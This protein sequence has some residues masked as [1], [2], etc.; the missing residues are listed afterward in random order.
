MN[1]PLI[2]RATSAVQQAVKLGAQ[3]ARASVNRTRRSNVK[4]R[5]GK[6]DLVGEST[7]MGLGVTL[8]VAGRYSSHYTSDLRPAAVERFLREAIASTRLLAPDPHRM[9]PDPARYRH[10][11]AGDLGIYDPAATSLDGRQRREAARE[12]EAA[13]RAAEGADRIVSVTAAWSDNLSERAMATSNGME[14]SEQGTGFSAM[15][16]VSV[17]DEGDRK[18]YAFE[19]ASS[20]RLGRLPS[21][22]FVGRGATRRALLCLGEKPAKSG[23]YACVIENRVLGNLLYGLGYP[24]TGEAIQ[25]KKS[26]LADKRGQQIVSPLLTIV[27]DPLLPGGLAS[28][29]FDREGMSA[30]R[31]PVID[32]GVLQNF[33]LDTYYAGKLGLEATTSSWS[34]LVFTPGERDLQALLK[35]MGTG[36]LITGFIGGNS[37]PATGDFSYGIRGHWVE[38]GEI[39]RPLAEMNLAGNHLTLWKHLAEVGN[40]PY[41]YS[42]VGCPS[43]RFE[44]VQF[45][46]T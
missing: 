29:T 10:R 21:R 12:I 15:G 28:Y 42:E 45:S 37:N 1:R 30:V 22:E 11:F 46:G 39:E 9:L 40:D 18:P 44:E 14:G 4:W 26:F 17:R 34:N 25:Q 27:D 38:A 31:R 8:L 2:D 32:K 33:F 16:L 24:L 6:L 41:P 13:A 20:C 43:V 7:Q 3:D 36:I 5:D 35:A 23:K 19:Y